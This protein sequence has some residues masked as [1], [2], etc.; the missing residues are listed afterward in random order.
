MAKRFLLLISILSTLVATAQTRAEGGYI[1]VQGSST[2][3][4]APDVAYIS[5]VIDQGDVATKGDIAK[6]EAKIYSTLKKLGIDA[7]SMLKVTS[8]TSSYIGR[9][10]SGERKSYLLEVRDLS[11]IGELFGSLSEDG[12]SNTRVQSLEV[13]DKSKPAL[14]AR[15]KAVKDAI[16]KA[17]ALAQAAAI[18]LG[19]VSLIVDNS[20]DGGVS[21]LTSPR[22]AATNAAD[23]LEEQMPEIEF[24]DVEFFSSVTMRFSIE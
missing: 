19:A 3:K 13:K 14:E 18:E 16:A 9:K 20:R 11:L 8:L 21:Y 5:I 6:T 15:Q 2:V 4:A 22:L 24:K 7:D 10:Q 1:E 17:E 12:I 23:N